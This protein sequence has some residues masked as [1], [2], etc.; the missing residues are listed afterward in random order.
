LTEPSVSLTVPC[1]ETA[2]DQTGNLISPR[3]AMSRTPASMIS[4]TTPRALSDVASNSPK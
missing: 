1:A 2:F 3:A 4:P